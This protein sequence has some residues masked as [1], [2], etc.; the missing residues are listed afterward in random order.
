MEV[1]YEA[2][3]QDDTEA[4]LH[5]RGA[6]LVCVRGPTN[7]DPTLPV[8]G[9]IKDVAAPASLSADLAVAL[10]EA[11]SRPSWTLLKLLR[12]D[13]LFAPTVLLLTLFLAAGAVV[14]EALILRSLLDLGRLLSTHVQRMGAISLI[15]AFAVLLL[16]L[17]WLLTGSLLRMGRKLENRLRIAFFMK[18]PELGDRYF[19]SR[20]VSDMAERS[21]SIHKLRLLP[22]LRSPTAA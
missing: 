5:L 1:P 16:A 18:W 19:Q 14:L 21:H 3:Y 2:A 12:A 7:L 4:E 6:V 13:G 10:S 20:L 22:D 15:L 11:P 8:P 9:Q 17:E